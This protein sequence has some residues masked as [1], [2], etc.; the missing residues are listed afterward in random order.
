[1]ACRAQR[2]KP[3]TSWRRPCEGRPPRGGEMSRLQQ[4]LRVQWWG[5]MSCKC[6]VQQPRRVQW[7]GLDPQA[8]ATE[9]FLLG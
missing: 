8:R 9:L 4:P 7:W 3:A 6:G 1:M 5:L 2:A